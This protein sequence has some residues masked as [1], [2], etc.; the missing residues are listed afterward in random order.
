MH[1]IDWQVTWQPQLPQA[2]AICYRGPC[3]AE[4]FYEASSTAHSPAPPDKQAGTAGLI[5]M[6]AAF[7]EDRVL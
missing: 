2:L 1:T 5:K 7:S 6:A 3:L 4:L